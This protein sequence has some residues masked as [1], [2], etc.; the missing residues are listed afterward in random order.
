MRRDGEGGLK[1]ELEEAKLHDRAADTTTWYDGAVAGARAQCP[2]KRQGCS[3]T[4]RKMQ[5]KPRLE[6][7]SKANQPLH[8]L[9]KNGPN[10]QLVSRRSY[11]HNKQ[12]KPP[13]SKMARLTPPLENK[14][15]S[16]ADARKAAQEE[17]R[18]ESR[19]AEEIER[20]MSSC[21][22]LFVKQERHRVLS[23]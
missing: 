18:S 14:R 1:R 19:N 15:M 17:R 20:V 8:F 2:C 5:Q 13:K 7:Q 4:S 9:A 23:K 3:A 21:T 10:E 22:T 11:R 6:Q 12:Q 16:L